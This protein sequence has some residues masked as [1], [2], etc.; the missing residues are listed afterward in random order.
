MDNPELERAIAA[1]PDQDDAFLVYA[2][3]LQSRGHPRGELAMID[4]ELAGGLRGER[5]RALRARRRALFS[6]HQIELLGPLAGIDTTSVWLH[7]DWHLGFIRGARIGRCLRGDARLDHELPEVRLP[8]TAQDQPVALLALRAV[9]Q[10][11]AARLLQRLEIEPIDDGG[12]RA[13]FEPLVAEIVREE[14]PALRALSLTGLSRAPERL[15][16]WPT[17][18]PVGALVVAA[19]RLREL[20]LSSVD[21]SIGELAFPELEVLRLQLMRCKHDHLEDLRRAAWP[22]LHTLELWLGDSPVPF[23]AL[24]ETLGQ[25]LP[26]LGYLGLRNSENTDAL[27]DQ[28]TRSSMMARL[29]GLELSGGTLTDNGARKLA[30]MARRLGG[31][32]RLDVSSN[33]LTSKGRRRLGKLPCV[34]IGHQDT[35]AGEPAP[36]FPDRFRHDSPTSLRQRAARKAWRAGRKDSAAAIYRD[37]AAIARMI[38]DARAEREMQTWL[39]YVLYEDGRLDDAEAVLRRRMEQEYGSRIGRDDLNPV[40][41]QLARLRTSQGDFAHA[42][43]ILERVVDQTDF[44]PAEVRVE[45][46]R[47]HI[48]LSQWN[49]ALP[50]LE[51]RIARHGASADV[52]NLLGL[53]QTNLGQLEAA[54][55]TYRRSVATQEVEWNKPPALLNLAWVLWQQGRY[56]ECMTSCQRALELARESGNRVS[57]GRAMAQLGNYLILRGRFTD[58]EP[59]LLDAMTVLDDAGDRAGVAGALRQLGDLYISQA[60]YDDAESRMREAL[61]IH[62]ESGNVQWQGISLGGLASVAAECGD[63]DEAEILCQRAMQLHHEASD[64]RARETSYITQGDIALYRGDDDRAIDAYQQA[65]D[66]AIAI[67]DRRWQAYAEICMALVH[68]AAGRHETASQLYERALAIF[69]GIDDPQLIGQ[70]LMQQAVLSAAMGDVRASEVGLAGARRHLEASGDR[71]S[72]DDLDCC[73]HV[74]ARALG[75]SAERQERAAGVSA[76]PTE[77]CPAYCRRFMAVIER[78]MSHRRGDE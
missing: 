67:D 33:Y 64:D 69:L 41:V 54:E 61:A 29:G 27:V 56:D 63:L 16:V 9:L 31:L 78:V 28:L 48:G 49:Q 13:T 58:A 15:P 46:A 72:L 14:R 5:A 24:C 12:P 47:A 2:D 42:V 23:E 32:E 76:E 70:T 6:R 11:P 60:R 8:R 34:H 17:A 30:T 1:D 7:L 39:H 19:P 25:R 10:S 55:V 43:E 71:R 75:W 20:C 36:L 22:L 21:V 40:H 62:R 50:L 3:W 73:E 44:E 4:R 65:R 35:P 74:I 18:G 38:G 68:G 52:L 37:G 77:R 26:G 57:E 59:H 45:L 51:Q 53:V 66:I